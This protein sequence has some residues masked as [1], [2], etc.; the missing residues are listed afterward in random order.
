MQQHAN[1][2]EHA[3]HHAALMRVLDEDGE[4]MTEM[5]AEAAT[6]EGEL[7]TT[8]PRGQE[9][10]LRM[11]AEAAAADRA[12]RLRVL[13]E[14]LA[15]YAADKSS[16]ADA[17]LQQAGA[18]TAALQALLEGDMANA[19]AAAGG[20]AGGG[21][22]SEPHA[23][24]G[25][26]GGG[27]GA[28]V[29]GVAEQMQRLR[30]QLEQAS[31]EARHFAEQQRA[32]VER[33]KRSSQ[34]VRR[35]TPAPRAR[36]RARRSSRRS[37]ADGDGAD[38]AA[39]AGGGADAGAAAA[40]APRASLELAAGAGA[41]PGGA[42]AASM[43]ERCRY[44][45]LR[46]KLEERR[47]LR[48]LEAALNVS[49]YT[50]KVDVLTWRSKNARVTAQIRDLCAILSG[51]VV[52]QDYRKGQQL[53][54]DREFGDNAEFFQDVFEIG[55]RYKVMNPDKMRG[56]YGKLMYMLM[57]SAAP[58]IRELLEFGC[59]R[60]LRT[61]GGALEA[62]GAAALLDDPL[63]ATATA[64]IVSR[65]RP[66]HEVQRD[67]RNKERAREALAR[68]YRTA[69]LSEEDILWCL[70]S[71]ADNNAYLLFNRDPVDRM[72]SYFK[73]NFTP[74]A[75]AS[76]EASLAITGGRGGARLTHSHDRQYHFVLQTLTLWSEISTDMFRLWVLAEDDMLRETNGYRLCDTGQGLNRVQSAP[77]VSKAMH[78]ILARC[79]ARVGGWVGSSVVHLGDHNVPNALHFIDK[80][81]QV[82]RILNPVVLV[83]DE[84]PQLAA[85][86]P[87]IRAYMDRTFGG[88]DGARRSILVDFCRH[89]FDGSGADNFFDAGSC[90]DGR[91][92]SAWNWCSKL[93]KKAYYP[94]FKLAGFV[95]FDGGDF[96]A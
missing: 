18:L 31:L 9:R 85:R 35:G 40:P 17:L 10:M 11:R 68:K 70:Y 67:I 92:T 28:G 43:R 29:A 46:L 56:E 59:V 52:A 64:E 88:V 90:I 36:Q 48:L 23:N 14:Q 51:L 21:G 72:I 94:L 15:E 93:E 26:G 38:G 54:A 13:T 75:P 76:P 91:L 3:A 61:V 6:L 45:P 12:Q 80:Y 57:D 37:S 7:R 22:G 87:E 19:A 81:T 83:L 42:A 16:A 79:Q 60:P 65:G 33:T 1:P 78:G 30:L 71:I 55:R 8:Q 84:L 62:G 39:P 69:A 58:A 77:A 32:D 89:A 74:G 25:G 96:K 41:A 63:V 50:D 4:P 86:D 47:L 24:G 53:V 66:R 27:G 2:E 49:E 73:A 20:G 5:E 34:Q 82:P 44:L 95:G